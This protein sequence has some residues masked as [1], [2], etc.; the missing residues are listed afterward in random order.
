MFH[1]LK[2]PMCLAVSLVTITLL[3]CRVYADEDIDLDA[4]EA[5][6]S[7]RGELQA[8][9]AAPVEPE[10]TEPESKSVTFQELPTLSAFSD[11]SVIQKKF[12]PKTNRF[13][14][15]GGLDFLT[16]NPFFDSYGFNGRFSF[17]FNEFVGLELG[18]WRH[19]VSPRTV[20]SDLE[21]KQ[22]I[23]TKTM[24][25][26]LGYMGV[27]LLYVPF[28][29]KMTFLDKRIIPY[30][31]YISVGAGTTETSYLD[32]SAPSVHLGTGEIFSL[33]KS[34]AWRWDFSSVTYSAKAP[35]VNNS[36]AL[37]D[38]G[39]KQAISDLYLGIGLTIL[40]PGAS[41]R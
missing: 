4:I 12:M 31:L 38:S 15:Y 3:T 2:R 14:L 20:T 34:F 17:F 32:K 1:G 25:S 11:I 37:I 39:K 35:E 26:S 5:E 22:S 7:Q 36:G 18:F 10:K 41:Y 16:N 19:S 28:Y 29:G 6:M 27:S 33:S 21:S 30:D 24:L 23:T 13:Q 8:Q 40:F 9:Q